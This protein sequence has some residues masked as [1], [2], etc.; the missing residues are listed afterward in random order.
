MGR[1]NPEQPRATPPRFVVRTTVATL[2]MIAGVLS[3]VFVGVTLDVRDRVRSG[4][5]DK[6]ETGQRMLSALEE[7]RARELDV[8]AGTLAENPTLKAAVDTYQSELNTANETFRGEMLVTIERELKKLAA[9]TKADVLAVTDPSG[10]ILAVAGEQKKDWPLNRRITERGERAGAKWVVLPTGVFQFAQSLLTLQ[11]T[12][13]GTLQLA[14]KL[15]KRYAEE[16]ATLSGADTVIASNDKVIASTLPASLEK[17]LTPAILDS[18]PSRDEID[19]GSSEYAIQQLFQAGD[20]RVYALDSIDAATRV[21]MQKAFTSVLIIA[22]S[23]FGLATFASVWLARTISKPIDTLA[24]SLSEM[25]ASRD[26]DHPVAETGFSLEVDTL[27]EAFNT[28]MQSVSEAEAETRHAYVGAIR[29][30]ALALDAR[31]PYTAGHSERVSAIAVTVGRQMRLPDDD[32]DIL[33][34]GA[35]LHDIGKIGISDDVLRKPGPLTAEEFRLIEQHPGV[36]ARILKSVHFLAPHLPIVELH[37]ERPDGT[38]ISAQTARPRDPDARAHRSRR[39]CVRRH[40]QRARLSSGAQRRGSLARVVAVRGI[41]VRC[42]GRAGAG[43]RDAG[44]RAGAGRRHEDVDGDCSAAAGCRWTGVSSA[45]RAP[46]L[47]VRDSGLGARGS[48]LGRVLRRTC[49]LAVILLGLTTQVTAQSLLSQRVSVEFAS[50][51][52]SSSPDPNDPFVVLDATATVRVTGTLDV[53]ARPWFRRLPG[54]DWS[55]EMYQLQVRYQPATKIPLRID[56]GIIS[57]PLGI[58]ALEMRPDRNPMIGT[59]SYY[60]S[61][62]PSF[63]G[64]FDRVQ[65]LSGGYPLGAM[66]SVS[67]TKWDAR[68]GVT[69]GTP[70][71]N[72]KMM[73]SNRPS[74]EPQLVAGGGVT[75]FA[76]LRLGAGYAHGIYREQ[77]A[78]TLPVPQLQSAS[79]TVFNLEGEYAVGYTRIAGEWILDSFETATNPAVARGYLLEAVRTLS[80]RWYVAGRTTRATTPVFSAGARVRKASGTGDVTVGYRFSPEIMVKVGYQGSRSYVATEWDHAAAVSLVFA[81][82]YFD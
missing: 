58:I 57:S 40:D 1:G 74:A 56:A 80:P 15:D 11:D 66:A 68:G 59:P 5:R 46:G 8:Q 13:F 9:R 16:I 25:T 82:R 23:A 17:L 76:G 37:H 50:S 26:F 18:L 3:A 30:L 45:N 36:G 61:P 71:R 69:D 48:G 73:S 35:L 41:A 28:M 4:A 75:P 51:I 6:L 55:K 54:G 38:G 81:K 10:T 20:A 77:T 64:R 39:R 29:A 78:P 43:E 65:L 42:R 72:R 53:I 22:L 21:P 70:A 12:A 24:R 52:T 34:L 49:L 44:D 62:L 31:D 33:R 7:R 47:G 19:L 14:K 63:D 2:I 79:A 67:G 27:T 32:L 60:F